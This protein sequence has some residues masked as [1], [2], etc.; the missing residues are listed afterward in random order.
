MHRNLREEEKQPSPTR[1]STI[2][3][4]FSRAAARDSSEPRAVR[5]EAK[6]SSTRHM[7]Q[8][9][10]DHPEQLKFKDFLQSL[11]GERRKDEVQKTM[12]KEVSKV[13]RYAR[14]EGDLVWNDLLEPA[15][16]SDYIDYFVQSG[17]CGPLG[18]LNK[19]DR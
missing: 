9:A 4:L 15:K 16:V 5:E 7:P 13:L 8:F 19:L 1:N 10:K 12:C 2:E 17:A 3:G 14:P 11:D 6:V 18:Q